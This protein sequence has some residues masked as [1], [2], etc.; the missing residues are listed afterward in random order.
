MNIFVFVEGHRGLAARSEG[1]KKWSASRRSA[2]NNNNSGTPS[3]GH[4]EL[5]IEVNSPR[6]QQVERINVARRK[7][8][9][10][11]DSGE[12]IST[13]VLFQ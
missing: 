7:H 12:K 4:R 2:N 3:A 1:S 8:T 10:N 6:I 5:P 11:N 9:L 13:A